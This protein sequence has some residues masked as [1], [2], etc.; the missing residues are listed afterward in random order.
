MIKGMAANRRY[1]VQFLG[2]CRFSVPSLGAFQSGDKTIE[3]RRSMLYDPARLDLRMAWFQHVTLPAV[4]RQV[5][6]G[7]SFILLIG[8]DLPEPWQGHLR[9][10]IA[11]YPHIVLE[12]GAP[13]HH[14]RIC[15]EAMRKHVDPSAD[16]VVQ[17]RLD[18]DDAIGVDF[19]RRLDGLVRAMKR[20]LARQE[21]FAI[22][23]AKGLVLRRIEQGLWVEPCFTR[24][25]TPGLAIVTRPDTD[26]FVLDFQ[27]H[28]LWVDMPSLTEVEPIMYVRGAHGDN[29]SD[30]PTP[31]QTYDLPPE[32]WEEVLRARFAIDLPGFAR[33][34]GRLAAGRPAT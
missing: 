20:L 23:F 25:W 3:A 29:D 34:V 21:A 10:L 13:E 8:A 28:V 18:D 11:P 22:D 33:E 24:T 12:L 5:E 31:R 26:K 16:A 30:V 17:F 1:R 19:I 27:H 15:A 14:R 2:L 9:R 4:A 6:P 7:F 32:A